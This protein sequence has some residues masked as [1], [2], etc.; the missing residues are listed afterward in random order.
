MTS[1]DVSARGAW[2]LI[3]ITSVNYHKFV[4][5]LKRLNERMT[6]YLTPTTAHRIGE[7]IN[8][9][10]EAK[11]N[12]NVFF[13]N[14]E[15]TTMKILT[16]V[17]TWDWQQKQQILQLTSIPTQHIQVTNHRYCYIEITIAEIEWGMILEIMLVGYIGKF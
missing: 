7:N 16:I 5:Y 4:T 9:L 10:N 6:W 13:K 11:R 17:V 8:T 12:L 2:L 1:F 3:T 14:K 15:T